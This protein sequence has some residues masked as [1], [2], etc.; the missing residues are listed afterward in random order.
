MCFEGIYRIFH[1]LSWS[2]ICE[3][4]LPLIDLVRLWMSGFHHQEPSWG[5]NWPNIFKH[6]NTSAFRCLYRELWPVM[7]FASQISAGLLCLRRYSYQWHLASRTSWIWINDRSGPRLRRDCGL[8]LHWLHNQQARLPAVWQCQGDLL[9]WSLNCC[10]LSAINMPSRAPE[11]SRHNL[12]AWDSKQML[13]QQVWPD[14]L[15]SRWQAYVVQSSQMLKAYGKA[16]SGDRNGLFDC[17]SKILLAAGSSFSLR[18]KPYLQRLPNMLVIPCLGWL[19]P[20]DCSDSL[21]GWASGSPEHI[22]S[23]PESLLQHLCA[24]SRRGKLT[25]QWGRR[26]FPERCDKCHSLRLGSPEPGG[27]RIWQT[28]ASSR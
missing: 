3:C 28:L 25:Q 21:E 10:C 4:C 17:C 26:L 11:G 7:V 2:K 20:P 5:L 27:S 12:A 8:L 1:R 23:P 18:C 22:Q 15:P 19:L 14:S 6:N 9:D 13:M 16:F 24:E